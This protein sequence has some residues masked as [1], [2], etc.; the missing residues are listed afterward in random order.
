V[1]PRLS[2]PHQPL[3]VPYEIPEQEA[4]QHQGD[5][6]AVGPQLMEERAPSPQ[7]PTQRVVPIMVAPMKCTQGIASAPATMLLVWRI[8]STKRA[9]IN[10]AIP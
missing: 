7:T 8:P 1:A 2:L 6:P 4:E 9:T 5:G 10:T 3:A